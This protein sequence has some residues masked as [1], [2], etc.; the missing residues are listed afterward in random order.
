MRILRRPNPWRANCQVWTAQPED[1]RKGLTGLATAA[2]TRDYP[3]SHYRSQPCLALPCPAIDV[4]IQSIRLSICTAVVAPDHA[5]HLRRQTSGRLGFSKP[6]C[7]VV[8][9]TY[10]KGS[11]PGPLRPRN[12]PSYFSSC[13]GRD[14]RPDISF[15]DDAG[16]QHV[17]KLRGANHKRLRPDFAAENV[18]TPS[19]FQLPPAC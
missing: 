7:G 4:D 9:R 18:G 10:P 16:G 19:L 2:T 12:N 3:G 14:G 17:G 11:R 5:T 15:R 13:G 8:W 6:V 1:Q